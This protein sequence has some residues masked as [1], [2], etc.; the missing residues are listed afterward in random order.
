MV[1][2]L[3]SC[4]RFTTAMAKT[5]KT[6]NASVLLTLFVEQ[7]IVEATGPAAQ[8]KLGNGLWVGVAYEF[9]GL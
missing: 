1:L 3:H 9:C 2:F 6:R 4:G 8:N 7:N 5:K